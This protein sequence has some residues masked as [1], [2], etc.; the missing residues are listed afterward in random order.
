MHGKCSQELGYT[1]LLFS[2][3]LPKVNNHF[4]GEITPNLC[5]SAKDVFYFYLVKVFTLHMCNVG[6]TIAR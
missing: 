1:Y 3:T 6:T 2:K 5:F 4:M